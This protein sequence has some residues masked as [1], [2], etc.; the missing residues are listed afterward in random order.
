MNAQLTEL[1]NSNARLTEEMKFL[2]EQLNNITKMMESVST[3]CKTGKSN[4]GT[5]SNITS[6]P[7]VATTKAP[8]TRTPAKKPVVKVDHKLSDEAIVIS[9]YGV[10]YAALFGDFGGRYTAFKDGYIKN[11]KWFTSNGGLAFGFGWLFDSK[12]YLDSVTTNLDMFNVKYRVLTRE[13]YNKEISASATTSPAEKPKSAAPKVEKTTAATTM[14]TSTDETTEVAT[15]PTSKPKASSTVLKNDY[16]NHEERSTGFVFHKLPIGEGGKLIPVA[17][18]FQD[19]SKD[20]SVKGIASLL[21]LDE[22]MVGICK[23]KKW[24]YLTPE[25]I[26]DVT[27]KD[28]TL[29]QKL[30]HMSKIK[31]RNDD[32][33]Q[34]LDDEV[35]EEDNSDEDM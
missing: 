32:D 21:P 19:T 5:T 11:N 12:L 17:I 3:Y 34:G 10:K 24:K 18:G 8:A 20:T 16:D 33:E 25:M 28:R 29:G 7:T 31:I 23:D 30:L 27:K 15:P 35:E 13:A 6:V 14:D 26:S 2:R 4:E 9:D 1:M 22:D